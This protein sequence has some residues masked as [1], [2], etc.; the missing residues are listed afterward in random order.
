MSLDYAILGFLNYNPQSGYDLKK[1]FDDSVRHF[2][3]ADQ[4]QIY[5]TLSRLTE[6]GLVEIERV[7]QED[8]PDRKV[9][10]ITDAGCQELLQWLVAMPPMGGARS[11]PLV[12]VFFLGQLTDEEALSKFENYAE[13]MRMMLA[14]YEQVPPKVDEIQKHVGSERERFFWNLTLENGIRNMQANLE[15]AE[16]VIERIKAGQVPEK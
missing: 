5:R 7:R 1:T 9:Y 16:S 2:W 6:R 15:W 12:Q 14:Q 8:R 13:I 11:A 10:H 4:S 3:S